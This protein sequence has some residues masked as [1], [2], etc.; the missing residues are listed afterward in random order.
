MSNQQR[1]AIDAGLP[2]LHGVA[3]GRQ[4]AGPRLSPID[5]R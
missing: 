3:A 2:R 5:D 1:D 4:P